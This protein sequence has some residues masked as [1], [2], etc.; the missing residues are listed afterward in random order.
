MR[1]ALVL[2]LALALQ[3]AAL[4]LPFVHVHPDEHATEHHHG[5]TVHTHWHHHAAD[6]PSD[7][8]TLG[9]TD[10]D[11]ALA[12]GVF[13]AVTAPPIPDLSPAPGLFVLP[14]PDVR[15]A[16][17]S[18]EVAHGHDPPRSRLL[19]SRAPPSFLS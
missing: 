7:T 6:T 4:S 5:R 11:R 14:V 16:H 18:C 9:G 1:T 12:F 17:P 19:P 2:V 8:P 15:A 10:D 3:S 13:V